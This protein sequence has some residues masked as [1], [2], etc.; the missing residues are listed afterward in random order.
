MVQTDNPYGI[1]LGMYSQGPFE[2][3]MS[4]MTRLPKLKMAQLRNSTPSQKI[5]N[6]ANFLMQAVR[7][8]TP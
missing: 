6:F 2:L 4:N 5:L 3:Y 7:E 1:G 8:S